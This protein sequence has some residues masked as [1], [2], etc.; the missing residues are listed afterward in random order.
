MPDAIRTTDDFKALIDG[1][2]GSIAYA[3]HHVGQVLDALDELGVLD[4]TAII[5][6]GDHG[7][8]FGEHGQYMDHGMANEAVH[9]VPLI[10]RWPGVARQGRCDSLIYGLDLAPTLCE[11]LDLPVPARWDGHSFAAALRGEPFAGRPYLVWD[12]GIFT[13][14]RAVRTPDWLLILILHPGLYPYDEPVLLHDMN[15][16][17]HQATNLANERSDVV[18]Q[19]MAAL[20]EWRQ[21]QLQA[22]GASDPL[23]AMVPS[24]PFLYYTPEQMYERLERTGRGHRVP[25]LR[26]RLA[27]YRRSEA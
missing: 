19:L 24:G 10:V 16:D 1:Y 12:H 17:P 25:E 27:R 21:A 15:A 20:G 18:G 23:E 14:T 5:V 22:C 13:F 3:D 8:S 7:D 4:E 2:D 26:A 6:S 11:L 9:N